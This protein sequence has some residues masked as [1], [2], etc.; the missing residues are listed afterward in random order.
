MAHTLFAGI[1]VPP[2]APNRSTT[3]D[4]SNGVTAS[5][6]NND[7]PFYRN[8]EHFFKAIISEILF[9]VL[10]RVKWRMTYLF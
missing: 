9:V 7:N 5:F 8:N 2:T 1:L 3:C 10:L 4:V 6:A